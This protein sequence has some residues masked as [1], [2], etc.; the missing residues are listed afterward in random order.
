MWLEDGAVTGHYNIAAASYGL[1]VGVQSFAYAFFF[2]TDSAVDH[3]HDTKG[4]DLGMGPSVVLV[5]AG[6]AKGLT[7]ET[8]TKDVYVFIFGQKG[9]MA[10]AGIQG[11]KISR[12]KDR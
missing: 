10:G 8:A 7:L 2:M 6:V 5:D 12:L 3:L 4:W 11:S 9:L 1:Q